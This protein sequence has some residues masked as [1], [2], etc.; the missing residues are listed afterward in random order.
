MTA[1]VFNAKYP[2]RF[3][4]IQVVL[5]V[6]IVWLVALV[7]IPFGW[8]LYLGFPVLAAISISQKDGARYLEEDGARVTRWLGWVVAVI[9]Y[10]WQL[11]DRLP[12]SGDAPVRFE[13]ERS[14]TPTAGSALLRILTAI[15]SA[16]V[17]VLLMFVSAIVWVIAAVWILI[18]ETYP[19][20][21]YGFQRGV[22]RWTARLL[23]YL[24]S[25]VADYPPFSLDTGPEQ[26]EATTTSPPA[27]DDTSGAVD[28]R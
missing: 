25:L 15:P 27:G 2:Q 24:A 28:Q 9:A 7:G 3:D 4:R 13:V 19:E 22:V 20:S 26:V 1:V 10:M 17:L 12:T 21:L 16:F 6:V 11:T 14:G 5:R 18:A 23:A 8:I